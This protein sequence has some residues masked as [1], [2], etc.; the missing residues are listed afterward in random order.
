MLPSLMA[1]LRIVFVSAV[2]VLLPIMTAAQQSVPARITQPIDET[3]LTVLRGNTHPLARAEFDRG[4]APSNLPLNRMLLVL[5][6]SPQ[7][8]AALEAL[9]DEQQDKSSP[10]YHSWLTPQEFGQQFGPADQDIQ[11]VTSWLSAQGFQVSRISAGGLVIEFSGSAGQLQA[12]FH[13]AIHKYTVNGEDHWANS[14]DPQIPAALAP[15]VAGI[16]SLN[17]FPR[18]PMSEL[19]GTFSRDKVTGK[20]TAVKP[21]FTFPYQSTEY[22]A[23]GPYD[24]STIYDVTSL[25]TS[26]VNGSAQHIAIVAET[27]INPQDFS[28]FH[29]MFGQTSPAPV[30]N[31]IHDGPDPGIVGDEPEADIDTQWSS[32]VAPGATIDLVVD[33]ST[34]TTAGV[35]LSAE[36][37]VDNNLDPVMSESYG[38]C[39]L[40]LGTTGNTYYSQLWEQAAAQ[41]I[42]AFISSGDAGSAVCDQ[43]QS[44][45]QNGLSVNGLGSTPY[46]VSVG[47][48]DFNDINSFSTYWSATNNPATGASAI[49]YIP[50]MTWNDS[51][52]NSE[53]FSFFGVTT[54]E[55]ACN[56]ANAQNEGLLAVVGGSGGQSNCTAP[57]GQTA[58]SCAGGYPKP[59]WQEGTGVPSD[60]KRDV[61]DVSLFASNGFNG[62]FYIVCQSDAVASNSCS[63]NSPYLGTNFQG[64]GG[65]SVASPALAGIMAL[66]N[67][68]YGR[69][70]NANYVLYGLASQSGVFH[71]VP[72]GST[73]AMPCK[74]P[75]PNCTVTT[76]DD[77]YGVLS[78][79]STTA[80]YD[81][82]TGLGSVDAANLVN[83]W[84]SAEFTP[85][86]TS[87]T[88]ST[89]M[90]ITH[91][92]SI[93]FNGSVQ[94]KSGTGTPSGA[95][96]L[97]ADAGSA[98]SGQTSI[99]TFPLT[100]ST[101]SGTPCATFSGTTNLLPGGTNYQLIAHYPGDS[102]FGASDSVG[103]QVSV[104]PEASKA[105]VVMVT[106]DPTTGQVTNPNATSFNYGS[107]YILRVN[108]DSVSGATCAQNAQGALGC[109]TG[110][111]SLT[112]NGSPLDGEP[113][114]SGTYTLNI[115]GYAEDQPIFIFAGQHNLVAKYSGDNSFTASTSPTDTV[116]VNKAP[117][118]IG[119]TSYGSTINYGVYGA[120][121]ATA[122][123]QAVAPAPADLPTGTVQFLIGSIPVNGQV[124]YTSA[125]N[126]STGY[127]QYIATLQ[128]DSLPLGPSTVTGQ[129]LGDAN[130]AASGASNS[131]GVDVLGPSTT[132]LS[133]S[134][135]TIAHGSSV[136]FTAQV[137]LYNIPGLPTP[138][139]TVPTPTGT[140]TFTQNSVNIGT[141]SLTNGT[142]QLA[143]SSLPG[144]TLTIGAYY[145][146]DPYYASS[147]GALVETIT[148]LPTNTTVTS[149]NLTIVQGSNVTFTATVK[150]AQS[151]GPALTGS[152]QFAVGID[153]FGKSIPLSSNGQ[154]QLTT[155]QLPVGTQQITA[156]YLDDPNYASSTATLTETV[157]PAPSF[158]I[159]PNP[160]TITVASP[161]Q[162]GST[163]ITFTAQGGFTGSATLS[164]SMCSN[165]PS[166]SG[167]SFSPSTVSFTSSTT[168][169]PVNL[170]I[171]TT[172][173]G[174]AVPSARHSL[175]AAL[176][177][178]TGIVLYAVAA[179]LLFAGPRGERRWKATFALFTFAVTAS[180]VGCG[181]GGGG[182]GG[183]GTAPS[184]ITQPANRTVTAGQTAMFSVMASG[185][186]PLSYQWQK[187]GAVI[188][189]ATSS[190]Y[191]TAPTTS[192][193]N[194][195]QFNVV[196]RNSY[197]SATS[198]AATLTV[199]GGGTPVG[200]YLVPVTV[201]I[202]GVTQSI[203]VSLIVQ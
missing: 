41:G 95:I 72:V 28:D 15:V 85:T 52:T 138:T 6:R 192:A 144:G 103:T 33:E 7:Q 5:Q 188:T 125:T 2:F 179:L 97:I 25:W 128:S 165:L 10:N 92:A 109:P 135:T 87:L 82:A 106:F 32:A 88:V 34:E 4:P 126:T 83:Q 162:S 187:N 195:A 78:G 96:S 163:T 191:T 167:C 18:R 196:V 59:A 137:S 35:D 29:T 202:N 74:N 67:Q 193:D 100:S 146:G 172:G 84:S 76:P 108:V 200:N 45:A 199:S 8:E 26:G 185:T 161:G 136:T 68:K 140:I 80:G 42:T 58:T 186:A 118:T 64:Y 156:I 116:T 148:L 13:T 131:V 119:L 60:G 61:P 48:T 66:V 152:V 143:T 114:G 79:Y 111:V 102:T 101:C 113:A 73:I 133:A 139:G 43:G 134:N 182:G 69:Q 21:A 98:A 127:A 190:T 70:G 24:F 17:N 91:G 71:D 183:G 164:G 150:P 20:V 159:T 55:Q 123:T 93:S 177:R 155:N 121:T 117:T 77:T 47:G 31:V 49:S 142:A 198:N 174:A 170:T 1:F 168:S 75:S 120:L 181:G 11:T 89:A 51:C 147:S 86:S 12:A 22:Y 166:Q 27:D 194:G 56:N 197:G 171:N 40:E 153:T 130:Y 9:L 94:P 201:T 105:Q 14:S 141:V 50:E 175:G 46:N 129:Y 203:T 145:S 173:P 53:I 124:A 23:L 115:Q 44:Y 169:V 36:Y 176:L 19:V 104:S 157:T 65:T 63:L 90:P 158:T 110:T 3:N 189:G 132:L 178:A 151:G 62:S 37:I 160:A 107:S 57:T 99:G 184:V 122:N 154:A 180:V 149:S 54:A 112:D 16:D 38:I 39:E 81:L 30:L